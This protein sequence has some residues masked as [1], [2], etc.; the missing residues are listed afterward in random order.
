MEKVQSKH[1]GLNSLTLKILAC[2]FMTLDHIALLFIERGTSDIIPT[3]YYVLRAIGKMAFPLFAFLAVEGAYHTKN[4][5]FYLLRLGGLAVLMDG[6]GFA[7]GGI[8][9]I[10]IASNPLIGNAFT[11]MFMGVLLITLLRKRNP[12]SL[13]AILPIAYEV[14]SDFVIDNNYGT[15]FKSDWGTF[16]I[17]LFFAFFL[18]REITDYT[19]KRK[20]LEIHVDASA[21]LEAEGE[22][23]YKYAMAVGLIF[24]EALFYLIYRLDYTAFVLPNEFIPIGTYSTLAFVFIL[25]YNGEKGYSNK[26]IQYSFYAYYPLHLFVLGIFSM[27]FGVLSAL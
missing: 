27:F 5:K 20:A 14:F 25:F 10:S 13:F 11:D 21:F 8:M 24:V 19:L 22:K 2:I 7:Y 16:S 12:Y 9:N 23:K 18:C 3:S 26:I 17:V 4:V 15:L 6:F 1:F